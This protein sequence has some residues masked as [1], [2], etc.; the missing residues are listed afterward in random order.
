MALQDYIALTKPRITWLILMSTAIGFYFGRLTNATGDLALVLLHLLVGT[1][2]LASGTAALN[3]WWERESDVFMTRTATRPLP[4]GKLDPTKAFIFGI[5]LAL[6][7]LVE[8]WLGCNL[9]TSFLGL[10]TLVT[11][12]LV[13]TPLKRRSPHS[14]TIGAI[15]GAMPPLLGFAAATGEL[16][17][18]AWALYALLFV[19]QFPHFYAIAWMYRQEYARAGIQMLP[20]VSPAL[21]STAHAILW[22]TIA[23][24]PTSLAPVALSMAGNIYLAVALLMGAVFLAASVQLFRSRAEQHART[25]LLASVIYLPVLYAALV[26][27][28]N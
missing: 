5:G 3:Q 14:T 15:P 25:V 20:V 24:I 18:P 26:F 10:F 4:S 9:L 19:W 7:G 21:N 11:Y 1:A 13:Y 8:L 17:A 23:L 27:A 16:S 2:L 12:L 22:T 28:P 6:L